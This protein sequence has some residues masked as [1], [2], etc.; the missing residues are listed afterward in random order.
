MNVKR[1][2]AEFMGIGWQAA[3]WTEDCWID[4]MGNVNG[5]LLYDLRLDELQPVLRAFT[6]EMQTL[7]CKK[8]LI[9]IRWWSDPNMTNQQ[10]LWMAFTS[11]PAE[12]AV[13]VAETISETNK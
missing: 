10:I 13:L 5:L 7:F 6:P 4:G 1:V 3:K 12:L 11:P 8:F 2:I 9:K